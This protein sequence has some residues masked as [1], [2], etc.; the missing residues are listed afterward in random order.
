MGTSWWIVD[1]AR[2]DEQTDAWVA[3]HIEP[4]WIQGVQDPAGP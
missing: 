3:T 4:F 2:P 1:W